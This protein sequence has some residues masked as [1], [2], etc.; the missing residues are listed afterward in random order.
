MLATQMNS[1]ITDTVT[2]YSLN[3]DIPDYNALNDAFKA[4]PTALASAI[5]LST[6]A[7]INP[8]C[9]N[10]DK[11]H[12]VYLTNPAFASMLTANPST[13]IDPNSMM[14]LYNQE[15]ILTSPLCYCLK[16]V[17]DK[18]TALSPSTA[19]QA[20]VDSANKAF[21]A[22]FSTNSHTPQQRQWFDSNF[23]INKIITRK[24]VSKVSFV[25]I[26]CASLLF[27]FIYSSLDYSNMEGFYEKPFNIA[28][29]VGLVVISTLQMFLPAM[30]G[31]A[32]SGFNIVTI[33]VIVVAPALVFQFFLM[34]IVWAYLKI[35]NRAIHI[36]PYVFVTTLI[37]LI[38]IALFENGVFDFGVFLY[39]VLISHVLSLAYA[40][41]IF[42]AHVN[43]PGTQLDIHTLS[44]YVIIFA[45]V[46]LLVING[47][48]PSHPTSCA[49]NI[50][51]I[52]PWVYTVSVFGFSIFIEHILE[53][54]PTKDVDLGVL[55]SKTS[56]WYFL[57]NS[58]LVAAVLGY[59]ML[60]LWHVSLGDTTLS[61]AGA[62]LP[63]MN[64]AFISGMNPRFPMQ[65]TLD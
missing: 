60:N 23:N 29:V 10:P 55:S 8:T 39:Y 7:K 35:E 22:C 27:N 9:L 28:R 50:T 64:F 19:M 44:G 54:L 31:N 2:L 3:T 46:S 32:A 57:G 38:S 52:L 37:S 61:N 62:L 20:R 49:Q 45:T 5:S 25:W 4:T 30:F 59:Y 21:K 41:T 18:F 17:L 43:K 56:Q 65:Y 14:I 58:L 42:F 48:T 40:A 33:T 6:W 11:V 16:S 34:E 15:G 13:S 1:P 12:E 26:I 63:R 53:N 51:R 36:H 47:M 24:S